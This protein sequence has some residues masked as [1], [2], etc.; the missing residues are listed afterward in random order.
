MQVY[1]RFSSKQPIEQYLTR[2]TV[3]QVITPYNLRNSHCNIIKHHRKLIGEHAIGP[4]NGKIASTID[5]RNML[6]PKTQVT[7]RN[8]FS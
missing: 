3:Q 5:Q 4:A 2:R 6:Q 8:I 1:R 7:E